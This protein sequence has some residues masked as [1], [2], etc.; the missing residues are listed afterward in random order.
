MPADEL[1][2]GVVYYFLQ[3]HIYSVIRIISVP[4]TSDVHAGASSDV[5][6][7]FEGDDIVVGVVV[8]THVQI[9]LQTAKLTKNYYLC[10]VQMSIDK[11]N[12]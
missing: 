9:L 4:K 12:S 11:I 2:N 8:Q 7:P 10:P 1:V 5:F 3:Q 6:I